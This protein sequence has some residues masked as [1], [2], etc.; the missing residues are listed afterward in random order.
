[1]DDNVKVAEREATLEE[2]RGVD[3]NLRLPAVPDQVSYPIVTDTPEARTQTPAVGQRASRPDGRLHGLGQTKYIDDMY[4]PGMIHAKIKRS[5]ISKARIKSIDVSEAEKMPGVMATL[6][7][8]EIPVNSFGPSYQD[9]PVIADDMVFHAGDAVAAVAAVTEQL[10]LDALEKIKIEYEPLDPVYDPI[11]AM[12]ESAP[13][14]HEGGSN[15]YAT[16]VIQKGD[17]EQGFKDAYRIYENTFSTQMVEHVPMEP[18][19]SIADWDG[20]GRVTL[21]SSLGRITLGRADI[22]RTLDI[23]INRVRIIA[24]VVGGNFGGKNEI[25]TEP[26]LA[27]LSK[28]TG[29]PV[30]GIYTR[31]DEFISSTTRHPFVMDYKTGVDKDGKIVARKVRLV[32]DGGAYCSWSETTLGKACILSAGPYNIDNLYVEAFAVYTN[33]TMTGA[34]RGFGAPQ[35]CFAYESHMDDIALDLGIDPLEIRMRNAFHEGSASP[36]GQVL[37]SVVVKDSLEKAA[38]RFGWEEWSK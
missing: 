36:T 26:I 27:L 17:V 12:K 7:G 5:G 35:V 31:E 38:D 32:C 11:E 4:F 9:Q 34:M 24:T 13:Q 3:D 28:K 14:V 29:R 15:V 19:A 20:N 16:K 10:A 2:M 30:K 25:T 22:S 18:H 1:M 37:Q 6:T 23:P 33:K 21:H 8:K